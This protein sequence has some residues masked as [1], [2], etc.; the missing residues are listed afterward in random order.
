MNA[1]NKILIIDDDPDILTNLSFNFKRE[2]FEVDIADNGKSG[3]EKAKIHKPDLIILDVIMPIMD[4]FETCVNIRSITDI[5]ETL[6]AFL[7]ANIDD[8]M[9][10]RGFDCGGDDYIEKPIKFPLL[11]RRVRALIRRKNKNIKPSEV[12]TLSGIS[13][14]NERHSVIYN[15]NEIYLP[16]KEFELLYLLMSKPNQTLSREEIL[17]SA[18]GQNNVGDRTIDVHIR[19]LREKIGEQLIITIKGEGYKFEI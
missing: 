10:V 18:W 14:D 6:I 5:K 12:I 17:E 1:K 7:T 19:K 16:K 13:I 9:Q 3:I 2:G 8:S 11:L 4:G 15:G